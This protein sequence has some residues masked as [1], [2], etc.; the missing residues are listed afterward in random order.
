VHSALAAVDDPAP[1]GG[2]AINH[3]SH[4]ASDFNRQ[5]HKE[6]G[7][8][9]TGWKVCLRLEVDMKA[10]YTPYVFLLALL[11]PLVAGVERAEAYNSRPSTVAD[12]IATVAEDMVGFAV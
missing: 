8:Q 9:R 11:G 5:S 1:S 6:E 7:S 12:A 4:W 10:P 3:K 2:G